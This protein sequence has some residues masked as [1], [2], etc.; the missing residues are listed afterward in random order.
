MT[1]TQ[2]VSLLLQAGVAY[3][4]LIYDR[5][6][7]HVC[8]QYVIHMMPLRRCV[9]GVGKAVHSHKQLLVKNL[10]WSIRHYYLQHVCTNWSDMGS[11]PF[12]FNHPERWS[13]SVACVEKLIAWGRSLI[14]N[15][16]F[17]PDW[18]EKDRTPNLRASV[19]HW[20]RKGLQLIRR[21]QG[22]RS[23]LSSLLVM[24]CRVEGARLHA[25]G[26]GRVRWT[27]TV[28]GHLLQRD[29]NRKLE[30]RET[31]VNSKLYW[32]LGTNF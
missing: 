12:Q 32:W 17:N 22:Y 2:C 7:G 16:G 10:Y 28:F 30:F 18:T 3:Y 23:W 4:T 19:H 27:G 13:A 24:Q 15:I 8:L 21:L 25:N 31:E 26:R 29:S 20:S 14:K 9:Q 11:A 1:C 6:K 5:E